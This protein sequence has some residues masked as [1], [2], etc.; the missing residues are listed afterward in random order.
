MLALF[1]EISQKVQLG[2]LESLAVLIRKYFA[3]DQATKPRLDARA[4]VRSFGIPVGMAGIK[5]FGAIAVRDEGGDIRASIIVRNQLTKEQENFVLCHLLGHFVLQIQPRLAKAEWASS[6]FKELIE[7]GRRYAF[8]EGVTGVSA[9]DFAAEDA[10]DRFAAA[11]LM[12]GAML[13]RAMEKLSDAQK[14]ASV[15]GVSSDVLERR[16]DDLG[17]RHP[18][19]PLVRAGARVATPVDVLN[20]LAHSGSDGIPIQAEQ[21]IVE[22]NQPVASMSRA[23][24]AHSYQDVAQHDGATH[25]QAPKD[26]STRRKGMERIRELAMKMD[27]FSEKSKP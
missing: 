24:A 1:P 15:F 12:P 18:A 16:L 7:P 14:V 11:L 4:I 27:K 25:Q 5:Y 8:G 6:G 2:D 21:L 9:H 3:G 19:E 20:Q 13:R 10:A 17:A 22:V 26:R 23:F